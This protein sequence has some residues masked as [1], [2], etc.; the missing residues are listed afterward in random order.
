M[1]IAK[2]H[3]LLATELDLLGAVINED[4]VIPRAV[5][6]G[7]FQNHEPGKLQRE[8][9]NSNPQHPSKNVGTT[10]SRESHWSESSKAGTRGARPSEVVSGRKIGLF[11]PL[12]A[13]W[14]RPK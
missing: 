13:C 1:A 9:P 2:P 6:L 11:M 14:K 5:H 12:Q 3:N 8:P 4:K 10:S 7:E